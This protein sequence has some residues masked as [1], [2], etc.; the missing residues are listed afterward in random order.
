[1][2]TLRVGGKRGIKVDYLKLP[3]KTIKENDGGKR[4]RR[5]EGECEER[6]TCL[7]VKI[8]GG[9]NWWDLFSRN[10]RIRIETAKKRDS[11]NTQDS[12]GNANWGPHHWEEV[13]PPNEKQGS[14][15]GGK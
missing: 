1:M 6:K 13:T 10:R 8:H 7:R 12:L 11:E 14:K 2:L 4:G 15:V 9:G 5:N 3:E